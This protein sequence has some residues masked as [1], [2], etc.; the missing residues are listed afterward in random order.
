MKAVK[1]ED[2]LVQ[3]LRHGDGRKK[4]SQLSDEDMRTLW[5]KNPV[6]RVT[7]P[8]CRK[9]KVLVTNPLGKSGDEAYDIITTHVD[10]KTGSDC[11]ASKQ[12]YFTVLDKVGLQNK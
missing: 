7:C 11:V 10:Q 4:F 1:K 6:G 5:Y 2:I 8:H 12:S 3:V 9:G